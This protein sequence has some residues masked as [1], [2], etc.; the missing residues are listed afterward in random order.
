MFLLMLDR[1]TA[2]LEAIAVGTPIQIQEI[3]S[4]DGSISPAEQAILDRM[5][6]ATSAVAEKIRNL[7]AN[8]AADDPAFNAELLKIADGLD[9]LVA[10]ETTV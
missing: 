7:I 10:P 9:A 5:N 2:N 1:I 3:K 4:M 8:T 6:A